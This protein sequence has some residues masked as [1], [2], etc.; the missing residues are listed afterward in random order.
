MLSALL[1]YGIGLVVL[2]AAGFFFIR[3]GKKSE[4]LDNRDDTIK[5]NKKADKRRRKDGQDLNDMDIDDKLDE[6]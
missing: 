5:E 3:Y 6:L 1:P 2:I 4:R